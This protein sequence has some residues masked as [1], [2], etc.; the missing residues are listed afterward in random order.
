MEIIELNPAQKIELVKLQLVDMQRGKLAGLTCPYCSAFNE[1]KEDQ[2]PL[3]C[4]LLAK[5]LDAIWVAEDAEKAVG[6]ARRI[7]EG[8]RNQVANES[9]IFLC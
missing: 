4:E 9:K 1:N 7:Y 6:M 3:C 8:A 2:N 5:C